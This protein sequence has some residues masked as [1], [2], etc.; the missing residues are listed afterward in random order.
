MDDYANFLST[1]H[2]RA[3]S[4]GFDVS[5]SE[6]NPNCFDY[7][8]A[9]VKWACRKGRACLF[10]DC[11][12]GKGLMLLA[13]ADLVAKHTGGKILVLCPLAV[14]R[15]LQ[16][17]A[18]RFGVDGV[19][20]CKSQTDCTERINITNYERLHLFDES[21]FAGLVCDESSILKS[22]D[23][24]IKTELLTRF[25]DVPFKLAC[26]ATP[27]PNDHMELGNH[28]EFVGAMQS[29][30]MLSTFFTHDGGETSKWRLRGHAKRVFWEWVASWGV[31]CRTPTDLGFDGSRFILPELKIVEHIVGS[32]K[33]KRTLFHDDAVTLQEQR[34]ARRESI[35]QRLE[36]L[37]EIVPQTTSHI[38][39]CGLNDESTE[40]TKA[41][42]QHGAIEVTGSQDDETK[43][44]NLIGFSERRYPII[45]SKP[46][47]A[48]WG[49]NWQHCADQTFF[50]MS[51]SWEQFYQAIR[52]S[53]RFG[54]TKPVTVNLILSDRELAVLDNIKRKQKDADEMVSG[55]IEAVR[56]F[57]Q[58]ELGV[59]QSLK[60]YNPQHRM[61]SPKWLHV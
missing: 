3:G 19:A 27:A 1:K 25:R 47:I 42:S 41:L 29:T 51:N 43:S 59:R 10:A 36:R 46:K 48:G 18:V 6:I 49:L 15:Q 32:G 54:Q 52:R 7:Q 2:Y 17:E 50:G 24:S 61:E 4:V 58:A 38:V 37:M 33:S 12:L 5:D 11:G 45:V 57:G 39:W 8:R 53:Y 40:A 34:A 26:T 14:G 31:F 9:I 60:A 22:I 13:W 28:A 16:S 30:V 44:S 56:D 55:M 20:L 23:G 35:P 21:Q